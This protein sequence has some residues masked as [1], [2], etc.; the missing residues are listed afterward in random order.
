MN[1]N[2]F[3]IGS[4]I[5]DIGSRKCDLRKRNQI[6]PADHPPFLEIPNELPVPPV[7]N[8]S[9]ARSVHSALLF[10]VR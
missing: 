1:M 6:A 7:E 4:D 3:A 9:Y 5:L 10:I 8:V 2:D